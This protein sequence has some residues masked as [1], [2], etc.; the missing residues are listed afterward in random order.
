MGNKVSMEVIWWQLSS[1]AHDAIMPH[2]IASKQQL[3]I[4]S[5]YNYP[6]IDKFILNTYTLTIF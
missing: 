1:L 3:E 2:A 4:W 5:Q 6:N